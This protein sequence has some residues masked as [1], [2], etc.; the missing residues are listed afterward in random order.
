MHEKSLSYKSSMV[1]QLSD[2]IRDQTLLLAFAQQRINQ[3]E[4]AC[5][6]LDRAF[7]IQ[8]THNGE[9]TYKSAQILS[10]LATAKLKSDN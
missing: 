4:E 6:T 2:E 8:K 1:P 3:F 10:Q 9:Y 7:Q 5:R